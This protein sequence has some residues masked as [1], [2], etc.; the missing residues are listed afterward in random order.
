MP[1]LDEMGE[2]GFGGPEGAAADP[3][4]FSPITL[5]QTPAKRGTVGREVASMVFD[6]I[7]RRSLT[8]PTAEVDLGEQQTRHRRLGEIFHTSLLL[9]GSAKRPTRSPRW[10]QRSDGHCAGAIHG[11]RHSGAARGTEFE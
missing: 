4:E 10:R 2:A 7:A 6:D 9:T 5:G 1:A 3:D 8:Q 11:E